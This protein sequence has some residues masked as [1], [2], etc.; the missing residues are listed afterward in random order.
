MIDTQPLILQ[1][2]ELDETGD[3]Y[4]RMRW[5]AMALALQEPSWRVVNLHYSCDSRYELVRSAELVVLF[6]SCDYSLMPV[7]AE[8][9]ALG[10]PTLVE[11]NDNFYESPSW[12]PVASAWNSPL[13]WQS[14]E[15]WLNIADGVLVTGPGLVDLFS[16]K[17]PAP[18]H[19]LRNH[20]YEPLVDIE[21]L[22]Q[23]KARPLQLGWAGS[24]GHMADLL[25]V[26]PVIEK[27]LLDFPH[28]RFNAMGNEALPECIRIPQA[29]W[30]FTPWG[31][32]HE[33]LAFWQPI[34]LGIVPF[35]DTPY[36]S[37]RSDVKAIEMVSKGVLPILPA[38]LPYTEFLSA[39]K[40]IG[41]RNYAELAAQ[42]Q[43]YLANPEAYIDDISR[44]YRYVS[45]FRTHAKCFERRDLYRQL[46]LDVF[47]RGSSA[48][49]AEFAPGYHEVVDGP[50]TE[51]RNVQELRKTITLWQSG[52]RGDALSLLASSV[53]QDD[54]EL[55][56]LRAKS[57][58][59]AN[60]PFGLRFLEDAVECFPED[61]RFLLLLAKVSDSS[62]TR[63][64]NWRRIILK[65]SAAELDSY[66]TFFVEQV[67]EQFQLALSV[68]QGLL[69]HGHT[70]GTIYP[71]CA[72]LLYVVASC[73]EK[74]GDDERA[75]KLFTKVRDL[76]RTDR[77]NAKFLEKS[78]FGFFDAWAEGVS[79]RNRTAE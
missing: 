74:T 25:S 36:N 9:Q 32:V 56:L 8:R 71:T 34:A 42:L 26:V 22:L 68:D 4:H 24:L 70:L 10:L 2:A 19:I 12:G 55:A 40:L 28:T 45:E 69:E 15:R 29:S 14:Y 58:L 1:I 67:V 23:N 46:L 41:W 11:Y 72:P 53:Y 21:T 66:R 7:V 65:L 35:L 49:T 61:L 78:S 16:S 62:A 6:Q 47:Q 59:V 51:P 5:P 20:L 54:P 64:V 27:T 18:I 48:S 57:L 17:T 79:A 13:I 37:C 52:Q 44:C 50:K 73:A 76:L 77:L 38:A 3:S 33:Y 30:S 60:P 31:T 75:A 63:L 43:H 39:C